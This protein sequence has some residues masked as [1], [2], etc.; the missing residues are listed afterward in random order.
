MVSIVTLVFLG[1][2][3]CVAVTRPAWAVAVVLTMFPIE[4][5]LQASSGIFRDRGSLANFSIG[6]LVLLSLTGALLRG[7][8]VWSRW[9]TPA[10]VL[11]ALLY[12]YAG[13]SILWTFSPEWLGEYIRWTS[14]YIMVTVGL[15]PLLVANLDDLKE[16][17]IALLV[18]GTA[19]AVFIITNPNFQFVESDAQLAHQL[20]A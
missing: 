4:Q 7:K 18:V 2:V 8:L 15:A 1:V 11:T 14:P 13:L 17:R 3:Y 19:V 10:L 5:V 9:M 16:L 20:V 6:T 12:G